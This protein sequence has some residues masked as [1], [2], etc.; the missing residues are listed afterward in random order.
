MEIESLLERWHVLL[1]E[2]IYPNAYTTPAIEDILQ[3][4]LV[5]LHRL[6]ELGEFS[7]DGVPIIA[8]LEQTNDLL[9]E[10]AAVH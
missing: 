3:E 1:N 2:P 7:V 5:I 4:R 6:N 9:R 8:A 10:V